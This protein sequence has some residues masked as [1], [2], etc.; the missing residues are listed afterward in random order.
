MQ[1]SNSFVLNLKMADSRC[2]KPFHME[3]NVIITANEKINGPKLE[4]FLLHN[5]DN[6]QEKT[7]FIV[8]SGHHHDKNDDG[9][10]TLGKNDP[11]LVDE[12]DG[13]FERLLQH[14]KSNSC[15]SYCQKCVW[16]AKKFDISSIPFKV[17]KKGVKYEV[18]ETGK[19]KI[20]SKFKDLLKAEKPHVLIFA[21]CFSHL[22][23]INH[24][25]RA[26]GLYSCLLISIERCEIT[27]GKVCHLD[28]EQ[29][30]LLEGVTK[31]DKNGRFLIK[32]VIIGG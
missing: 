20:N 7:D 13:V 2:L 23:E 16:K 19:S 15:K 4:K 5:L 3:R 1:E 12:F 22:S 10:V 32:D 29:Q 21:S 27:L 14:S 25:L 17:N 11:L 28:K 18:S 31:V 24:I 9:R 8:L 30:E 6:F 26:S